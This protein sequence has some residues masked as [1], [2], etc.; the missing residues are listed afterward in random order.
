MGRLVG[1]DPSGL[2]F[3]G[4]LSP[5]GVT[6]CA[7]QPVSRS[8]AIGSANSKPGPLS[9]TSSAG[10]GGSS[11][12]PAASGVWSLLRELHDRHATTRFAAPLATFGSTW[13]NTSPDPP[14]RSK[15]FVLMP[16]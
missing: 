15:K 4:T 8:L 7:D 1:A 13:S 12:M 10:G 16:Q 3:A 2:D 11:R 14:R 6:L 5:G 9:V